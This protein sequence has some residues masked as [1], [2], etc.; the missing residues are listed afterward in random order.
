MPRYLTV[1]TIALLLGIV[2][3]RIFVLKRNWVEVMNF[4]KTDKTDI[5]IRQLP[6]FY[7]YLVFAAV[8]HW[9]AVSKQ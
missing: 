7:F 1:L 9:P 3:A 4:G 8:F 6:I 5:L 2:L